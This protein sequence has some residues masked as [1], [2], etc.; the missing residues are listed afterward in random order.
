MQDTFSFNLEIRGK[1][2]KKI[3]KKRIVF[4]RNLISQRAYMQSDVKC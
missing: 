1:T 3:N 2:Y 4:N